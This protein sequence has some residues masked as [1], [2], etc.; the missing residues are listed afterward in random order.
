MNLTGNL[1]ITAM[2]PQGRQPVFASEVSP[3]GSS[4]PGPSA[5]RQVPP[6]LKS[7]YSQVGRV[8]LTA[9]TSSPGIGVPWVPPTKRTRTLQAEYYDPLKDFIRSSLSN[10][11]TNAL[12]SYADDLAE[13]PVDE[14]SAQYL[15]IDG[16]SAFE[17]AALPLL[18]F[19]TSFSGLLISAIWAKATAQFALGISIGISALIAAVCGYVCSERCRRSTFHWLLVEE[20]MRRKGLDEQ[21]GTQIPVYALPTSPAT[22]G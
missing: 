6:E 17:R 20:I 16:L 11:S 7:A 18:L 8:L 15:A 2:P 5:T 12:E 9:E 21:G 13:L 14:P 19:V 1:E 22:K 4:R 3:T 10:V